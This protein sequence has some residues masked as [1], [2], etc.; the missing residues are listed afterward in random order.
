M[1]VWSDC[2]WFTA[3]PP[4]VIV[5]RYGLGAGIFESF[6]RTGSSLVALRMKLPSAGPGM[7]RS[8]RCYWMGR[9]VAS[10]SLDKAARDSRYV[11]RY[12]TV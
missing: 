9:W 11:L 3:A 10:L 7:A 1:V 5:P 12:T 6:L 8:G 2:G 4:R